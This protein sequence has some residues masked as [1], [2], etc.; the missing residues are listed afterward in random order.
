MSSRADQRS[1]FL[2]TTFLLP[3]ANA[4]G[5]GGDFDSIFERIGVTVDL[6]LAMPLASARGGGGGLGGAEG[7]ALTRAGRPTRSPA[8]RLTDASPISIRPPKL[9][10][11][12]RITRGAPLSPPLPPS[13][14]SPTHFPPPTVPPS[15]PR[16]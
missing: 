12:T 16:N 9:P 8:A 13:L 2:T 4:G 3:A 1:L 7:R 14:V 6:E 10:S 5:T 15:N 11:S